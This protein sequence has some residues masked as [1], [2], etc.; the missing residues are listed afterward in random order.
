ML[1]PLH[2][3]VVIRTIRI[4][5]KKLCGPMQFHGSSLD[6]FHAGISRLDR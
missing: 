3:F 1:V 6:H 2:P 4:N 5:H